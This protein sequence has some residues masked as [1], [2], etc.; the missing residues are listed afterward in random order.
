MRKKK[1][2][3]LLTI[4]L[5]AVQSM[6]STQPS[7]PLNSAPPLSHC[8]PSP[9]ASPIAHHSTR[10]FTSLHHAPSHPT[11]LHFTS[12]QPF[13]VFL[14]ILLSPHLS[15][16]LFSP[17][18]TCFSLSTHPPMTLPP[19]TSPPPSPL[20]SSPSPRQMLDEPRKS[21]LGYFYLL[22][23]FC[24]L[25][26]TQRNS[27]SVPSSAFMSGYIIIELFYKLLE[28]IHLGI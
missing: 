6:H 4:T 15:I 27:Y 22:Y 9:H 16:I 13:S 18:P 1:R 23:F 28:T 25:L 14:L 12:P 7:P 21:I 11:S 19:L 26:L 2:E 24:S 17:H 3:L 20:A 5:P 10:H 8:H